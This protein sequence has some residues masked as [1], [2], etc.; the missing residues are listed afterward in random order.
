M[1]SFVYDGKNTLIYINGDLVA[2]REIRDGAYGLV[3]FWISK[4]NEF[5]REVRF[6]DVARSQQ[7]VKSYVWKMVNPDE[8]GLLL[9]YPCNG[10]K[11]NLETGEITEDETMIWN[12]ASYYDGDKSKLNLPKEGVFDDNGG[13]LYTFPLQD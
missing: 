3:G 5:I 11:R 13:E 2:D 6:W 10:K 4:K 1:I 9:Y 7:Q 12:W 8:K